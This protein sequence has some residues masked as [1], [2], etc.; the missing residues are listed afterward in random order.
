METLRK[1]IENMS[2]DAIVA[3]MQVAEKYH[4]TATAGYQVMAEVVGERQLIPV[5]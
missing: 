5:D 2:T 4:C 3:M 1:M